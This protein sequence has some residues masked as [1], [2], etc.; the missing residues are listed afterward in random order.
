MMNWL[1]EV[2]HKRYPS[3]LT[4]EE[5]EIVEPLLKKLDPYTTGRPRKVDLREIVNAIFYLNKTGC[6]WRYL[7]KCFPSYTWVSYYYHHW[8]DR[9]ILEQIN[10]EIRQHVRIELGRN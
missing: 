4:D 2:P 8:V 7:P 6:Q 10:T 3:D 5:W 9:N 1:Q